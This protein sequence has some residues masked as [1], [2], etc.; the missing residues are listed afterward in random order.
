MPPEKNRV[1]LGI[2]TFLACWRGFADGKAQGVCSGATSLGKLPTLSEHPFY[3]S[4]R[5]WNCVSRRAFHVER[6]GHLG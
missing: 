2:R 6:Q 3:N 1:L 5:T 4:E